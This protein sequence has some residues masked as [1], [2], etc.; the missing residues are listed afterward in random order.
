MIVA[1]GKVGGAM[2]EKFAA[3]AIPLVGEV[4]FGAQVGLAVWDGGKVYTDC[5]KKKE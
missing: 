3:D 5:T 2:A 1:A 4:L